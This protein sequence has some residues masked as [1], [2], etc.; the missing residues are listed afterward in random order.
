MGALRDEVRH[1]AVRA[2]RRECHAGGAE[3]EQHRRHQVDENQRAAPVSVHR[4]RQQNRQIGV[5]RR[6]AGARLLDE[7]VDGS[8]AAGVQDHARSVRLEEREVEVRPRWFVDPRVLQVGRH[9]D[10]AAPLAVGCPDPLADCACRAAPESLRERTVDDRHRRRAFVVA[11]HELAAGHDRDPQRAEVVRG[12]GVPHER[13]ILAAPRF[14]ALDRH[15]PRRRIEE[16]QGRVRGERRRLDAGICTSRVQQFAIEH[17]PAR[18]VVRVLLD[19]YGEPRHVARI[20]AGIRAPRRV[21]AA[22]REA[23][24]DEQ[25]QRD[26]DL[27]D[28][29]TR[30]QPPAR[31]AAR[32]RVF[33]DDRHEIDARALKR[34][35][36]SERERAPAGDQHRK[37]DH[38]AVHAGVEED[39]LGRREPFGVPDEHR[40]PAPREQHAEERA[41]RGEH[42]VLDD[43][44]AD[45]PRPRRAEREAQGD[46]AAPR[47]AAHEHEP[48]DVGARDQQHEQPH[49]DQHA[50][51]RQQDH[52]RAARRPP[53]RDD[54]QPLG[55]IGE[56]PIARQRRPERV[57]LRGGARERRARAQVALWHEHR[58]AAV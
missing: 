11:I 4:P 52:R 41:W 14:V 9:A 51:R 13:Q 21:G 46:F 3:D 35:D 40:D 1:E 22:R 45:D 17:P 42:E 53:E 27:G 30:P 16:P 47:Q 26:G 20:E 50:E 48:R 54:S 57:H 7:V 49:R 34:R 33:V 10:H 18:F 44:Q 31:G 43:Q 38:E 39:A 58:R 5:E 24:A 37:T 56:R 6:H 29:E 55:R 12:D 23:R 8:R 36:E 28:H 15:A 25:Q 19:V 2:H 32:G